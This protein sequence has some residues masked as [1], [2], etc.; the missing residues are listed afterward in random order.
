MSVFRRMLG[1]SLAAAVMA[2][3]AGP[4]SATV[5]NFSYTFDTGDVVTGTFSGSQTGDVVTNIT[6]ARAKFDGVDFLGDPN[7]V[8]SSY[9]DPG[10]KCATCW[11]GSGAV[12][13]SDPLK[14]NFFISDGPPNSGAANYFYMAPWPN[15]AGN[16]E[17]T[18]YSGPTAFVDP[19]NGNLIPANWSLEA[20][21]VP[22][23]S[24]WTMLILGLGMLGLAARRREGK[25]AAV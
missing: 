22:E 15:G 12:F 23:P 19:Y 13:S 4:A 18:Q 25:A 14:N 24:S 10:D 6:D 9:T 3:L 17:A 11:T 21:G 2:G 8:V 7:L 20:A 16:P 1:A 5:F